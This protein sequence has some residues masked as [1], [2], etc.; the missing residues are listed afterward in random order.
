LNKQLENN[1][2]VAYTALRFVESLEHQTDDDRIKI[3]QREIV[4]RIQLTN[5]KKVEQYFTKADFFEKGIEILN[6]QKDIAEN[7]LFD[8][9]MVSMIVVSFRKIKDIET[10]I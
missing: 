10:I 2:E 5:L 9:T 1:L 4:A 3:G 6:K 8:Y 7:M